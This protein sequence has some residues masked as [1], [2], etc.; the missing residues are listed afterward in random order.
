MYYPWSLT[1]N[2]RTVQLMAFLCHI[3]AIC[4]SQWNYTSAYELFYTNRGI[5]GQCSCEFSGTGFPFCNG[6]WVKGDDLLELIF[7]RQCAHSKMY[8]SELTRIRVGPDPH[9]GQ[10]DPESV[11]KLLRNGSKWR[12]EILSFNH[13]SGQPDQEVGQA[14]LDPESGSSLTR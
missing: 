7:F 5:S 14:A 11:S 9:L 8:G 4:K 12:V 2:M 3:I 6:N 13:F 10:N 1:M